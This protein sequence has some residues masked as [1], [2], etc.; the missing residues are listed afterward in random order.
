MQPETSNPY[1]VDLSVDY[2]DA[3]RN[4]LTVGFRVFTALPVLVVLS[5][6]GSGQIHVGYGSSFGAGG[7]I[8]LPTLLMLLFRRK[9]PGWWFDFNLNMVRFGSRVFAYLL[10]LRD[11]YPSTDEEQAV[12][13][14]LP[15]PQGGGAL[16]R[17]LPLVKWFLAIP[18]YIV[19]FFLY[20]AGIV[21]SLIGWFVVLFTGRYP[22]SFHDFVVGLMRWSIR[23][24]AYTTVLVTDR[25]PP[26]QLRP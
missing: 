18:H 4:R 17:W 25:Y 12:H 20:I 3:P 21:L 24:Q 9:Y 6:L 5:L 23:V 26:F 22:R 11:E 14:E 13:I 16:N 2:E 10:I 15:D 1:P 19:L 8:F 7:V